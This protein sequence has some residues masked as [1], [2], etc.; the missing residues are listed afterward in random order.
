MGK[1]STAALLVSKASYKAA[2]QVLWSA[3]GARKPMLDFFSKQLKL[4]VR[5]GRYRCAASLTL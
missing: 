1:K 3:K 2:L 4:E 5:A